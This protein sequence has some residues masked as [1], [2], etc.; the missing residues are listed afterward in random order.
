[1]EMLNIIGH[2]S[3][4]DFITRE[5][6]LLGCMHPVNA[7]HEI[8]S[9]NFTI[10]TTIKETDALVE[11]NF[12]KPYRSNRQ[13]SELFQKTEKLLSLFELDPSEVEWNPRWN[14]DFDEWVEEIRKIYGKVES[15]QNEMEELKVRQKEIDQLIQYFEYIKDLDIPWHE[16]KGMEHFDFRMGLLSKENMAKLRTNYDNTPAIVYPVHW[17]PDGVVVISIVP[18]S[19]TTELERIYHSLGYQPIH[20]SDEY[21]GTPREII[22]Q[23]NNE[24]NGIKEKLQA[25]HTDI[26]KVKAENVDIIRQAYAECKL[27]EKMQ[28]L[29]NEAACSNEFFYMAGWIPV[30]VKKLLEE[31]LKPVEERTMISYKNPEQVDKQLT[32]PTLLRNSRL[33]RPFEALVNMYGTPSYNEMD[34]TSFVGLSYMLLF[35][36][37]FGDLGQ[38][39]LFFLA[40]LFLA[41]LKS[42]TNLGGVLARLGISSMLFGVL[43]GSVF[44]FENVIPALLVRPMENITTMLIAA[45]VLGVILLSIAFIYSLL[46]AIKHRDIE[47][48]LLGKNGV[49]GLLFFWSLLIIVLLYLQKGTLP[50]PMP[51]II[52]ILGSL[53]LLMVV[54]QPVANLL[55]KKRPLYREKASDYYVEEGFGILETILSMLSNTISFVRVGAFALNHVG[56]FVAFETMSE[57]IQN[58]GGKILVLILGN[59]V[60]IGLEGLIVFIQGL[61][62]E[63]YELFGKYYSGSGIPYRPVKWKIPGRKRRRV[64]TGATR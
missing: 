4:M 19:L 42:R 12:I 13:D 47:E 17:L 54:R 8:D 58:A 10:S 30:K 16:L 14:M 36:A 9:N 38:G 45:V 49:T 2:L 34:P 63:Y 32:P 57:M 29:K 5:L 55:K 3:D 61:R 41:K 33:L 39:F 1:M 22:E 53:L 24:R 21:K 11:I 25:C 18:K 64:S 50:L 60:I 20:L 37:M 52:I 7:M 44:G 62:L 6:V 15:C 35:G 48:G 40:G 59:V 31:R 56:L 26:S 27:F 51:V 23:L 28:L 46:N 43:Y